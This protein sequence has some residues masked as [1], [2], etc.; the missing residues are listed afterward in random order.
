MQELTPTSAMGKSRS[1]TIV[2]AYLLSHD[3]TL[4]PH[5]A[6]QLLRTSRPLVEPNVG[7]M[8]QLE[9]YHKMKCPTNIDEQPEYQRWLYQ[10]EV[11]LSRAA[12]QPPDAD[13][14]R[15]EDEHARAAEGVKQEVQSEEAAIEIKCRKCRRP[16]ASTPYILPH[17]P[18]T[19]PYIP[20]SAPDPRGANL[21]C[22]HIFLEPL[23]WMRDELVQGKMEGKL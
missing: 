4:T 10:R 2:L 14:I 6:L 21:P 8:Y 3:S 16:L 19:P 18:P 17:S 23:S 9:L 13:K 22:A 7:F 12:G 11:E 5:T 20:P 1:A 15:F